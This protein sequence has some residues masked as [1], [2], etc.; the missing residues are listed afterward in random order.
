MLIGYDRRFLSDYAADAAAEVF[1]GNNIHTILLNEDGP[2]PLIEFAAEAV[3]AAYG[4]A[5]TASHNSPEWN[6]LKVF[7]GA[8]TETDSSKS[9]KQDI[10]TLAT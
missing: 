9:P 2:T 8:R 7:H 3:H 1:A 6:G 4:L 5:F 10:R